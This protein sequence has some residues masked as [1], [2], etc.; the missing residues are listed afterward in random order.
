MLNVTPEALDKAMSILGAPLTA[1]DLTRIRELG[2][3]DWWQFENGAVLHHAAVEPDP[4][5]ETSGD[6]TT[7]C[8]RK[9][10]LYIPGLFTRMDAMRCAR[11][12]T[13]VGF[14]QGKGSPKNDRRCRRLVRA[15]LKAPRTDIPSRPPA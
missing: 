11:C 8:G 14:P 5:F 9:G 4:A 12:C 3:W 1:A 10:R 2:E 6:G 15:R 13:A 7:A